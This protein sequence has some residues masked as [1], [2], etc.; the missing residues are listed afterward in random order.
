VL[1]AEARLAP[2]QALTGPDGVRWLTL[3]PGEGA[4]PAADSAV[5]A[6]LTV[7]QMDGT[8]I[9]ST[10]SGPG[11][12]HFTLSTPPPFVRDQVRALGRGG[13]ARGYFPRGTV[14]SW[15]SPAW[16]DL[17]LIMEIEIVAVGTTSAVRIQE[18]TR[19]PAYRFPLPDA[20]GPPAA[21]ER[22]PD[23]AI[24]Y[25]FLARGQGRRPAATARLRLVVTAWPVGSLAVGDPLL[26]ERESVTT[27]ARAGAPLSSMLARMVV[28][29]TVRLWLDPAQARDAL[30]ET[31]G[32][33]VVVDLTLAAVE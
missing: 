32:R 12:T 15:G 14:A 3:A 31:A 7:W 22:L 24:P 30:P 13:R 6:E 9:F 25:L 18:V 16:R 19:G 5:T 2:P 1:P 4:R 10:W 17:A 28:G 8:L 27:L 23:A 33:E 29:D 11:P 26:R 21:A 20:A